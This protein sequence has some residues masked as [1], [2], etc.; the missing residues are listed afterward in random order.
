MDDS[1]AFLLLL[2]G[3]LGGI[4]VFMLKPFLGYILG[5][6]LLAFILKPAHDRLSRFIGKRFSAFSLVVAAVLLAVV[7]LFFIT[8]AVVD[9]ARDFTRDV[10]ST[11]VVNL[12]E[13]EDRVYGYT[14]QRVDIENELNKVVRRFTSTAFGGFRQ[15][16]NL[17]LNLAIG[18]PLMLFLIYYLLKDGESFVAWLKDVTPL[19]DDVQEVLYEKVDLTTWAVIKGHVFVAIAQGLAGGAGLALAGVPNYVFWT[20]MMILLGIIPV[21]GA[22]LVWAPAAVYLFLIDR[23]FAASFLALYGFVVVGMIDNFLRPVIVDRKAKLNP[24][25]I[26]IGVIGGVFVFGAPGL[27]IGPI[28]LGILKATLSVFKNHYNEI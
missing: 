24:A 26:L 5:S 2:V 18:I 8:A 10:N 6:V 22:I 3:V 1:K 11:Q 25:V 21:V 28:L 15:I 17:A 13:V 20:F 7:P 9:D 23:P 14:G 4:S 16:F 12:T 19:P 27:F